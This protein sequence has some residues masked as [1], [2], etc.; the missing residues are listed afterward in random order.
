MNI[1]P[2]IPG[3]RAALNQM[4][5]RFDKERQ[6]TLS[7]KEQCDEVQVKLEWAQ[8]ARVEAEREAE[9]AQAA[10]R[11]MTAERDDLQWRMDGLNK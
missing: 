2:T 10:L 9:R 6:R 5:K 4:V 8:H 11:G 1:P 3:L 7:A